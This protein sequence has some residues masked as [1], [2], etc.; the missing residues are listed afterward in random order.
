MISHDPQPLAARKVSQHLRE[1]NSMG[2]LVR[3]IARTAGMKWGAQVF[4]WASTLVVAR[5]LSAQMTT[6]LSVWQR[7]IWDWLTD[8]RSRRGLFVK[9]G[10]STLRKA[11]PLTP[12]CNNRPNH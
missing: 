11:E 3:G 10:L 8:Q 2:T 12:C 6:G 4:S 1:R 5:L 7:C 9:A